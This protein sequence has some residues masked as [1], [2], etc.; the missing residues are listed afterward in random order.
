MGVIKRQ[1]NA[2]NVLRAIKLKTA[3]FS[4]KQTKT[5]FFTKQ[6]KTMSQNTNQFPETQI[7]LPKQNNFSKTQTNFSKHKSIYRNTKQF[8]KTQTNFP[9]HKS[10][11]RNTK[12][13]LKTLTNFPE[14]QTKRLSTCAVI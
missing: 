8:L 14:T 6:K 12:Q 9:K 7:S 11:Y 10:V 4:S 2:E 13:L 5:C 3:Q 1:T